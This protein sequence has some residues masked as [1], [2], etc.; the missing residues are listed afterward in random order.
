MKVEITVLDKEKR[1]Q[2]FILFLPGERVAKNLEMN[3]P[4]LCS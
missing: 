4:L 1:L 3:L 2:E